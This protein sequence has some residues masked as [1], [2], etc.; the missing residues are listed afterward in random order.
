MVMWV[1]MNKPVRLDIAS[2]LN[3]KYRERVS[4]TAASADQPLYDLSQFARDIGVNYDTL[5]AIMNNR[6]GSEK[7]HFAVLLKLVKHFG[8]EFTDEFGLTPPDLP[9]R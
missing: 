3:R 5:L 1:E 8:R 4:A 9:G 2:F 7:M 6:K